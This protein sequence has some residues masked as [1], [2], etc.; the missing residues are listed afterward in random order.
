MLRE[1]LKFGLGL[2]MLVIALFVF[3]C[4]GAL[5]NLSLPYV[6][7]ICLLQWR[8]I[9]FIDNLFDDEEDEE[10]PTEKQER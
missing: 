3:S 2:V 4:V 8:I 10:E 6:I 5:L 9:D 1:L 7:C